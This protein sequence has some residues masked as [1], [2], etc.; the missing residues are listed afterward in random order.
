MKDEHGN[1]IESDF[2]EPMKIQIPIDAKMDSP[3]A[4][5]LSRDIANSTTELI[6]TQLVGTFPHQFLQGEISHLSYVF[7]VLNHTPIAADQQILLDEDSGPHQ[8]VLDGSDADGD[9]LRFIAVSLPKKGD[10]LSVG[11]NWIYTPFKNANGQ[12]QFTFVV[13][14]G[15]APSS[16]ATVDI[17]IQPVNDV[18]IALSQQITLK[19]STTIVLDGSDVD[20]DSLVYTIVSPPIGGSLSG[21]GQ[22][23]IY[24]SS[25]KF[26][27]ADQFSFQISDGQLESAMAN[28]TIVSKNT[29]YATFHLSIEPGINLV[30][31]PFRV[32]K[33]NDRHVFI[34][35]IGD[36]Y[37]L[38]GDNL[39]NLI[40]T[41]QPARGWMSYLGD[42]GR[43]TDADREITP[44]LGF[45]LMMKQ[46][47]DV[48]LEGIAYQS[49][50]G[51]F[52]RLTK[53]I[54]LVGLPVQVSYVGKVSDVLQLSGLKGGISSI[55]VL[56]SEGD[57]NV[58]SM[59]GDRGDVELIGG[60]ALVII[61]R[62]DVIFKL[63]GEVRTD[64]VNSTN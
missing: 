18:P 39:V 47:V 38:L 53:G 29:T 11:H 32:L 46:S 64:F 35:T 42:R 40:L 3:N 16:V 4:I 2:S 55:I 31:L 28:V 17:H 23:L 43:G 51:D 48:K 54:N 15:A 13:D 60:Q 12:D 49:D 8:I 9:A 56:S 63:S 37:H 24:T 10:L 5:A 30:H 1:R 34:R 19:P 25:G 6:P 45:I 62:Q 33:M 21:V 20:G 41:H 52:I 22:N 50:E 14:D 61:A 59:P 58:V 27:Q 44:D 26:N 36:F 57:F 7:G